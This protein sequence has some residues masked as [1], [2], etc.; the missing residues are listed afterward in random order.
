MN[1][2]AWVVM[3]VATLVVIAALFA[4]LVLGIRALLPTEHP[5]RA[6]L[7]A[8]AGRTPQLAGSILRVLS[9]LAFWGIV[10]LF[11]FLTFAL[12]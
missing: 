8:V 4:L 12:A 2:L 1:L 10:A 5:A 9:N 7:L 11:G 6:K 3:P